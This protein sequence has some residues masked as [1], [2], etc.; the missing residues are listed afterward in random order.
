M[1]C[2]NALRWVDIFVL[3][4]L[5]SI[6]SMFL[7]FGLCFCVALM[8]FVVFINMRRVDAF[9]SGRCFCVGFLC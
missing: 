2:I 3:G 9:A 4:L 1:R 7:S 6:A 5:L 8:F